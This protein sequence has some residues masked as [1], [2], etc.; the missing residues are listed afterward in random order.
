MA[1]SENKLQQK[2]KQRNPISNP[3][4]SPS[5][6]PLLGVG[7]CGHVVIS[8]RFEGCSEALEVAT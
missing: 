3:G 7:A 6:F 5:D 4:I 8:Q 1:E 2:R